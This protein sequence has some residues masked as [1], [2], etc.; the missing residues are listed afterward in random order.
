[1]VRDCWL[2]LALVRW[3]ILKTLNILSGAT[4]KH[5]GPES[6]MKGLRP[7]SSGQRPCKLP[8]HVDIH[9]SPCEVGVLKELHILLHL[10]C[11]MLQVVSYVKFITAAI[12]HAR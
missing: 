4:H 9:P 8:Y 5:G 1:M 11:C 2:E 10:V 3:S 7:Q 6:A 12:V